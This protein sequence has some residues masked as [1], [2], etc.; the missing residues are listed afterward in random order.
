MRAIKKA[1][2]IQKAVQL[3][4]GSCAQTSWPRIYALPSAPLKFKDQQTM[5]SNFLIFGP[6]LRNVNSNLLLM[7]SDNEQ[8]FLRDDYEKIHNIKRQV[9]TRCI[10]IYANTLK[11]ITENNVEFMYFSWDPQKRTIPKRDEEEKTLKISSI[12]G[13]FKDKSIQNGSSG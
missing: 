7:Q 5:T 11:C 8:K 2:E 9:R 1:K 6:Y 12:I 4:S 3:I 10:W 13:G